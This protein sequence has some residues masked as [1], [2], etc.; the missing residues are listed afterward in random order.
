MNPRH[1]RAII[2]LLSAI[3]CV[4]LVGLGAVL[5]GVAGVLGLVSAVLAGGGWLVA[6]AMVLGATFLLFVW[7]FN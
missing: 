7:L 1:S 6:I 3:L 5:T 2:V 4:L